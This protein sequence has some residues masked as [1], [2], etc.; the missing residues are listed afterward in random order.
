MNHFRRHNWTGT[1]DKK[2]C[3]FSDCFRGDLMWPSYIL[4]LTGPNGKYFCNK[5][6]VCQQDV[7][8]GIPHSPVILPKYRATDSHKGERFEIRSFESIE[9]NA[10]L[11][12]E[13]GAKNPSN[14]FNCE[15]SPLIDLNGPVIGHISVAPLHIFL[16]LGLK[17]LDV[18]EQLAIA[19]DKKNQEG[20]WYNIR[21]YVT[22]IT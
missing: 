13:N 11:F 10:K 15:N 1:H 14:Y 16:G 20:E 9:E 7:A 6:L 12:Q 5:C 3:S 19:E 2:T 17:N 21:K 8:K 18:A 4:G 22:T